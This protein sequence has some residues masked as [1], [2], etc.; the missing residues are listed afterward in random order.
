MHIAVN[1]GAVRYFRGFEI[2]LTGIEEEVGQFIRSLTELNILA[3]HYPELVTTALEYFVDVDTTGIDLSGIVWADEFEHL[4]SAVQELIRLVNA[5]ELTTVQ[6]VMDFVTELMDGEIDYM[7]LITTENVDGVVTVLE[8]LTEMNLV[9]ELAFNLFDAFVEPMLEDM[10]TYI[11]TLATLEGYTPSTLREDVKA[12]VSILRNASEFGAVDIYDGYPINF[13]NTEPVVAILE[14][15]LTLNYLE[16][17]KARIVE[18][19]EDLLGMDLYKVN[20]NILDLPADGEKLGRFYVELSEILT[21]DEFIIKSLDDILDIMSGAMEFD[22]MDLVRADYA[23]ALIDALRELV[24]MSLVEAI[25]PQA[26]EILGDLLE[27][28]LYPLAYFYRVGVEGIVEDLQSL[29]NALEI[30][31]DIDA[32]AYLDTEDFV[33]TGKT[34]QILAILEILSNLN[35]LQDRSEAI[36]EAVFSLLDITVDASEINLKDE[37]TLIITIVE[38]ALKALE[39]HEFTKLSDVMNFADKELVVKDYV[40]DENLSA[41]ITI[42][43][44]LT[45]SKLVKLAFRLVFDKYVSPMFDEMDEFVQDLANL[46][47][48]SD[49]A[50]FADLDALVE[51]LRQLE[52]I[53]AVGIYRGEA[54][55][56]ANTAV[57]ETILTKVLTLNYI[58]VKRTVLFDF[59]KDMLPDIDFSE[60]DI[61]NVDF[62]HDASLLADAYEALVPVLMDEVNPFKTINDIFDFIN[63]KTSIYPFEF[64]T[65]EYVNHILDALDELVLTTLVK[66][67]IPVAFGFVSNIV[68]EELA[69]LFEVDATAKDDA[70]VDLIDIINLAREVVNIGAIDLYYGIDIEINKP[71]IFKLIVDT[72]FDLKTL[73]LENNGTQLVEALLTI[74]NVDITDVDYDQ[75]DWDNEQAILNDVIDVLHLILIDNDFVMLSDIMDFVRNKDYKDLDFYKETTLNLVVDVIELIAESTILKAAA[76]AVFDQVILPM[77]ELPSELE[78]LLSFEGYSIDALVEDFERLSRI[79]RY[80]IDFGALDIVQGGVINYDQAGLVKKVFEELF[81]LNFLDIKRHA[82]V[83]YID[84]IKGDLDLDLSLFD[85]DNVDFVSDGFVFGAFYEA[86][87]PMLTN[88][89]FSLTTKDEIKAFMDELD[90]EQF[91]KD[92]YAHTLLDALKVLVS[93]TLV[94]ELIPVA[95]DFA[96][97][98]VPEE[99]AFVLDLD[100]VTKEQ[101]VEDLMQLFDTLHTAVDLGA[102]HYIRGFEVKV[103]DTE[104]Q[105]AKVVKELLSLNLVVAHYEAAIQE[106][107]RMIDVDPVDVDL[108]QVVWFDEVELITEVVKEVVKA[109]PNNDIMYL[110]DLF[111]FIDDVMADYDIAVTQ[112]NAESVAKVLEILTDSQIVKAAALPLLDA[113]VAPMGEGTDYEDLLDFSDYNIDTLMEDVEALVSIIND[114]IAFG[115]VDIY[116]GE[117]INYANSEPVKAVLTKLLSLNFLTNKGEAIVDVLETMLGDLD[118]NLALFDVNEVD[119]ANDGLALGEFYEALLP[120][121]TDEAFTLTSLDAIK[122]FI[123][124]LD[125]EPLLKDAYAHTLLDALK[126]L[127]TTTLVKELIPVAFD[128]GRQ[129]VPSEFAFVFDLTVVTE[130]LVVEDLIKV[131]DTMHIAVNLGAVRYFR[132]FEIKLTGIEEEVGQFIRSL[133][134]LNILAH[135]YPELVTT[136]LEYFVDVDTTGIDLSGIVWADEFEHLISAVQELIRLVNA[137][138][139]TTVQE[140]MDFVTELMDGEIDYMTLITTENVDGVVT[141]LE[142]LTEM[143]LVYELAFNLFDAFVEPMLED[144]ATYIQTLATLEGYT[145]STLREDV[146]AIVS[147]LRNASEFGAVDIYDGYPINF[148]NTEPVV[149][150]LETLLSLNYLEMNKARIVEALE[151]LLG[152]DLYK[153]NLNVIDLA[154]DKEILGRGYVE[155]A[156]VLADEDF[157]VK[158][159]DDILDLINGTKEFDYMDLVRADYAYALIDALRELVS[160]SLVEAIIPQAFEILGDLL[161]DDLYPLAYFYRVGVEGIV[162]D[163]QSL[164]NALEIAV[165]ID[166]LAYLDTEDFVFTGKTEQILAIL[167]ILSNLN[168][169]QDRSEAIVEAVFSLLDITVDA[170][171]INLKDELTLIITIVEE[172]LKALERHEF[173]KLSDVMNFADKELVVKD[174]VTDENLSAVITILDTLT[175][176]KLVKLAFRLVFD[177]YVSPMFDEMDEFVQDLANLD[178]YSDDALF[179]DLDALVEVLRQAQAF[180]AVEIYKGADID[181]TKTEIVETILTKVL[182]LNYIDVKRTVLFDFAKDMLPDIDFSEVDINNV[183][184]AHDASLLADAYEALVPVLMDEVNPFKTIN[185]IFDFIN[186]K[187]SIYPF[188]FLTVEYV[189]HIL[190]ALDELVLTTLVKEAIPVAFGFVSNIVPE[191]LAFLFEVDATAKDDAIVDLIDI[192]NLAREVVNIGAIDLYYGIDI[193]I[194]KPEIFKLIVDTIFDL[195]TLDLE[196]NGTQLVEALLTIANVDITDVDYDQIDW[197]NEQAILNDVI[198]VLH[199]ILIDNDFVMLSDIMDF[200]RNKDYKDLDFYKETTL[201]L[202]VDAIEILLDSTIVEAAVF[203][204]YEQYLVSMIANTNELENLITLDGYTF[205]TLREDVERLVTVARNAINFGALDIVQG[206]VINYDQ[207]ELVK[208]V[209][210]E[211]F[212]LNFLEIKRNEIVE[213]LDTLVVDLGIDLTL[214]N[215]NNVDF[216]SDGFVFGA[217]YEALLPM[218]T[219]ENF[220]L[221]TKDEIKA[222]MDELDYEQFLKDAYVHTILDALKVLVSTTLVKELIPVAF[223]FAGQYVPEE[224]AFVLDLDVVT[225]E[226]VVEDLMQVLEALH[227]AVDLGAVHYIRGFEVKVADTEDQVAKVVKELLSLNLVVAHYEAA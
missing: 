154:T 172:A 72:I 176:S 77:F 226:Q 107:L 43:D 198:D 125:Y 5:N 144:M 152:M 24:S 160:M 58:D 17:N 70:I 209:F 15:L 89:N 227:T 99:F 25:I 128:F 34:E 148:A 167:E 186:G 1:L 177:K 216:V 63:G 55:D 66:E 86:L 131:L 68:P 27:D 206:G 46:D 201:N 165:D 156:K 157:I 191:E 32:L 129:M 21:D 3:H 190:D 97:Q 117:E 88:E 16:M 52:A 175:D 49:D 140:V 211:L 84:S 213:F 54:I 71:E 162:E 179:A 18:A 22:Y 36:V 137:N 95:F 208:K 56:Y 120:I 108:T 37:L 150:I 207:A 10:A 185:D 67:A 35:Y 73:D 113:F 217:F 163:L 106:A 153:V 69:F 132:G 224:F 181:F 9:Y 78:E 127:V 60:V 171:E 101:V 158:T 195:K 196:N 147:I 76:F 100:V 4:I 204:V 83:D 192:I 41:V 135:H 50:L 123:E 104:D 57:V 223:D 130:D 33:F 75:I 180:G 178:G 116:K 2:K 98:Y 193:E 87:L 48:Y 218:L 53:D 28:D 118:V 110:D 189:N 145:P 173:T 222:F 31:V 169:L 79:A 121:L 44:T 203:A 225:K 139:L 220:S 64:L 7:T 92:A 202:V 26:F 188:E 136:A 194:N 183:D 105:V 143:N 111:S 62:A 38:E 85:V 109:L 166:A 6:E 14:T 93:T 151:D 40:T 155:L 59:A 124:D 200:V 170:S 39:R 19:L 212:A 114:L 13:A 210:E 20:L 184:F 142:A 214:F 122:A 47:G 182:T 221:T 102:V 29:L 141:V 149:A 119:F 138:E 219:D 81:A 74:A 161:E 90:Y 159:L 94:K 8:A 51:V 126:V 164:L 215:V 91:L 205:A 134:E 30:A 11:Q 199:L 115:A 174:Y 133:T 12:I 103:A 187:T 65:V 96:G 23:Y 45:D 146:K 197:D 61:N 82:L 168:Y 112:A 42:L 80:A